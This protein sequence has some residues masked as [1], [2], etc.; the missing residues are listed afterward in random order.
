VS[1]VGHAENF[2]ACSKLAVCFLPSI[3]APV[4]SIFSAEVD[5]PPL[6]VQGLGHEV[7]ALPDVRRTDAARSKYRRPNG[8]VRSLQVR[9]NKVEPAVANRRCNLL[10]KDDCRANDLDELKPIR[11]EVTRVSKPRAFSCG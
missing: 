6:G 7:E 4:A 10:A 8:V 11:P 3:V 2:T 5:R 9:L 1:G